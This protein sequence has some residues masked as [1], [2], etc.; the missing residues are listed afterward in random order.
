MEDDLQHIHDASNQEE[1]IHFYKQYGKDIID[2]SQHAQRRQ[3]VKSCEKDLQR[4]KRDSRAGQVRTFWSTSTS[5]AKTTA[6]FR[7]KSLQNM[8]SMS[9]QSN[10]RVYMGALLH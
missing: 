1:L 5:T 10:Y 6:E 8:C 9:L 2:L 4:F 3:Q 7:K